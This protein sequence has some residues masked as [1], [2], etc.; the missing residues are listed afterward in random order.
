MT[1]ATIIVIVTAIIGGL[2]YLYINNETKP[3]KNDNL[4]RCLTES[5]TKMFGAYWCPH[6]QNQKKEF[7]N[8]WKYVKYIECSLPGEKGQNRQCNKEGI[9]SYPTWEF[10]DGTR[11][12]GEI[13]LK[14][15]AEKS[16]CTN[17][18]PEN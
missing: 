1:K 12:T 8:A 11:L 7:G 17:K 3:S 13:P 14:Q 18:L 2:G 6:C 9:E 5:G 10:S 4:A 15:L 16:G